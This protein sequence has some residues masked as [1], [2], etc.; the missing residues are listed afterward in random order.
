MLADMAMSMMRDG[1]C[2]QGMATATAPVRGGHPGFAPPSPGGRAFTRAKRSRGLL[3]SILTV[4]VVV[5]LVSAMPLF[6]QDSDDVAS[7][8]LSGGEFGFG[9]ADRLDEMFGSGYSR[10]AERGEFG[11]GYADRLDEM[12]GSGYADLLDDVA[13]FPQRSFRLGL[14]RDAACWR[15]GCWTSAP[16]GS[17]FRQQQ[18]QRFQRQ[19]S[20]S[21][22]WRNPLGWSYREM[23]RQQLRR[24][25]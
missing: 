15:H 11:F 22:F 20:R 12:F 18:Y 3:G 4:F 14:E 17:A 19:Q 9:Y 23:Q 7:G 16:R 13:S 24:S 10:P 2:P 5:T 25:R 8:R 21:D 1:G 6:A